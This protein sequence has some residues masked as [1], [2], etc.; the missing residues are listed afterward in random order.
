MVVV[1]IA[2]R[3]EFAQ[4][5]QCTARAHGGWGVQHEQLGIEVRQPLP[6]QHR[7]TGGGDLSE[8]G[9][10]QIQAHEFSAHNRLTV[11]ISLELLAVVAYEALRRGSAQRRQ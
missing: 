10:G 4:A 8:G 3:F 7:E 11:W 5:L 1:E 2:V 9:F 6:A